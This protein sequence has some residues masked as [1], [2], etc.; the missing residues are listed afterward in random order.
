MADRN[1]LDMPLDVSAPNLDW[2]AVTSD[3][4][5]TEITARGPITHSAKAGVSRHAEDSGTGA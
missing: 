1:L 2:V 5:F 3:K 4:L